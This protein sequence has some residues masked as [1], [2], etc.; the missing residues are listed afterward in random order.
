MRGVGVL[1]A[2]ALATGSAATAQTPP[3]KAVTLTP[4]ARTNRAA[5]PAN[6]DRRVGEFRSAELNRT[7]ITGPFTVAVGGDLISA[8]P[9]A[10]LDDPRTRAVFDIV[11]HADIGIANA[12]GNPRDFGGA[13]LG[14]LSGPAET[15]DDWKTLGFTLLNRASNHGTEMGEAAM[16]ESLDILRHA[17]LTVAGTGRDLQE[18]RGAQYRMTPKGRIGIVGSFTSAVDCHQCAPKK[19]GSGSDNWVTQWAT[20]ALG[21]TGGLPG[22]NIIRLTEY[23]LLPKDDLALLERID[24]DNRTNIARLRGEAAQ[25]AA[26]ETLRSPFRLGSTWYKLAPDGQRG[27]LSY[28]MDEEDLRQTLRSVRSGKENADFIVLGVHSHETP[29]LGLR[30][31]APPDFLIDYAHQAIDNGA[32]MVIGT[33]PHTLRGIEIYKGRPIFYGMGET[34]NQMLGTPVGYDRYRDNALDPFTT[35]L[36]DA[37]LNWTGWYNYNILTLPDR[38]R[39]PTGES[40]IA[41]VHYDR[42]VLREIVVTPIE[43][44][45]DRPMSQMGIPR[46]ATGAVAARILTGFQAL[47]AALGTDVRIVKERGIITPAR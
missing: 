36:T 4:E 29:G 30:A 18:A 15:A 37:E 25:P 46:I 6:F 1:L 2:T 11:R 35:D 26:A 41:E 31:E 3:A 16:L 44:A 20:Y 39:I 5:D 22:V 23:T 19:G 7:K 8:Y 21:N 17:G 43:L 28:R 33:G 32:D 14:G 40:A 38:T 47:C 42:G 9:I 10:G 34:I 12:E 45:Y 13:K 27:L 24:R